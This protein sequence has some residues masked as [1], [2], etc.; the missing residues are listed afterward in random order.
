MY[1][2]YPVEN[3]LDIPGGFCNRLRRKDIMILI[4]KQ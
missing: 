4:E 3:W 2:V 1:R